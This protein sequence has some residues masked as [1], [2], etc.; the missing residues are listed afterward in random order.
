VNVLRALYAFFFIRSRNRL[1]PGVRA[2]VTLILGESGQI[3]VYFGKI[4]PEENAQ[5]VYGLLL[6][7]YLAALSTLGLSLDFITEDNVTV[8]LV[9]PAAAHIPDR[10]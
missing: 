10:A 3:D 2:E 4:A 6:M 1:T 9:R 7:R 8:P 5:E